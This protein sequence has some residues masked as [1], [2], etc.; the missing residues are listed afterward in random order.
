MLLRIRDN[1]HMSRPHN[2]V[3]GLRAFYAL[4]I[5]VARVQIEGA[6]VR[7]RKSGASVDFMHKVGTI[8]GGSRRGFVLP[9]NG[10]NLVTFFGTYM[11]K[12]RSGL[13]LGTCVVAALLF[14]S[15]A[16]TSRFETKY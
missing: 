2:Q 8:Q 9:R 7:I 10:N 6:C 3:T 15:C 5:L 13:R 11:R 16:V 12:A 1:P 14:Y 4:K